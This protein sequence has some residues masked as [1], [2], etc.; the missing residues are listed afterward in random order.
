MLDY[1]N[2]R[3]CHDEWGRL[4]RGDIDR[5]AREGEDDRHQIL[6]TLPAHANY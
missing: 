4:G 2:P 3:E 1:E 6:Q 5:Q